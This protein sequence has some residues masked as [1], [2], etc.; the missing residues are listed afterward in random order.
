MGALPAAVVLLGTSFYAVGFTGIYTRTSTREAASRWI[1]ANVPPGSVVASEHWDDGIPVS[2]PGSDTA[3]P[4][5]QLELFF[6]DDATKLAEAGRSTQR[7]RLHRGDQQPALR[8]RFPRVPE[9]YPMTSE[10]YRTALQRRAR[11][12]PRPRRDVVPDVPRPG[13]ERR[14]RGRGIHGLR[15]SQGL[16]LH[17]N[18]PST[19]GNRRPTKTGARAGG[20]YAISPSMPANISCCWTMTRGP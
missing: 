4:G 2:L 13:A 5:F 20:A 6:P 3:I 1:Y 10:Y 7:G 15:P 19:H 12:R 9:R 11:L 16:H 18:E 17:K 8:R 14:R